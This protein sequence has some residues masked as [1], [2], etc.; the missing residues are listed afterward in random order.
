VQRITAAA[1]VDGDFGAHSLRAGFITSAVVAKV[2][3]IDI[4]RVSGHRSA[5]VLRGYVRRVNV[6]DAPAL[7]AIVDAAGKKTR[8]ERDRAEG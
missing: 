2:S 8:R 3:E 1:G 5:E 7:A 6:M 4:A